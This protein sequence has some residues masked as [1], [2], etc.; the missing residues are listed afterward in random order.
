MEHR[1]KIKALPASTHNALSMGY[2]NVLVFSVYV[3]F[4]ACL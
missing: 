3:S 2:G 4:S 1:T